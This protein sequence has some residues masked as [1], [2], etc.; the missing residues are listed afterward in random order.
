ML[1]NIR[2]APPGFGHGYKHNPVK[3]KEG[4][5]IELTNL[6]E[7]RYNLPEI[8]TRA[9]TLTQTTL[10][11]WGNYP[12]IE[13]R[14]ATPESIEEVRACLLSQERLIARGNGKCYGD[15]ALGPSVLSTLRLNRVLQF[16]PQ[17]GQIECQAGVLLADL[18]ELVVP[19]GWFFHVTP[20]IKFITVGGAIASDVHGKNHPA[21]GCFSNWLHSFELMLASG[22]IVTCSRTE[23]PDLFWQT[24]GGMGWTGIILSAKFQLMEISSAQL[25]QMTVRAA[26]LDR[27]FS[28]FEENRRW[29]Y[30][31]AWLDGMHPHGR[32]AVFLAEHLREREASSPLTFPA[33]KSVNVPLFAPAWLLNPLTI[34]TYNELFYR[35]NQPNEKVVD[36]DACF[37]PL[38][39][40]GHWNRLYGRRGFIQYQCCLPEE[41]SLEGLKKMLALIQKSPETPFL[42][43]LKRHGE[44]PPEAVHSFP[45]KGYSLAL[46]FPRTKTIFHLVEKLDDLVWSLGGKIYLTKDACSAP[47][48]GQVNPSA[49]G[50]EKFYSLLKERLLQ[51]DKR[52]EE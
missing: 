52:L 38:D 36:L 19:A 1:L 9:M 32:G 50:S 3:I 40:I 42:T 29:P 23:H 10:A 20:G 46:D 22:E 5:H 45:I 11:N 2:F 39:R 34:K 24:C 15:A 18:L 35:K 17:T 49:F 7:S 12:A 4:E 13:A 48:M 21:K 8:N 41:Q 51:P 6:S 47:R 31:V 37:Y 44:R 27:L 16:E 30:Q 14:V 25:R 28:A 43:V 26:D 33:K